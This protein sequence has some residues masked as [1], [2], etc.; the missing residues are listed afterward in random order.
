MWKALHHMLKGFIKRSLNL[1]TVKI[2]LYPFSPSKHYYYCN[3][4]GLI[5]SQKLPDF[6]CYEK[7]NS[8]FVTDILFYVWCHISKPSW[9]IITRL[10]YKVKL[11]KLYIFPLFWHYSKTVGVVICVLHG[12]SNIQFYVNILWKPLSW[13]PISPPIFN[14]L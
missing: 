6:F 3:C 1:S 2:R 7:M 11:V 4:F 9:H 10:A 12:T 5:S 13:E 8:F 14:V